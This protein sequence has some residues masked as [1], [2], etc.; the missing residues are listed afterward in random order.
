MFD[1]LGIVTNCLA[2][3][4]AH[5]DSFEKLIGEFVR[6]GFMHI[7]IR[8]GDYLRESAFGELLGEM[9]TAMSYYNDTDWQRLCVGLH[10]NQVHEIQGLR[11]RDRGLINRLGRF[12]Q[13]SPGMV[14]SY[15]LAHPWTS[16]PENASNDDRGIIRA[17]RLAY[18]FSPTHARLRLVDLNVKE[19]FQ[20]K[21]AIANLRRYQSLMTACPVTLAVEN[22]SL[23][24][25]IIL[26]L[27]V[28][29]NVRLAYDEANN[30]YQ[31]GTT[32]GDTEVFWERLKAHQLISIH[33]KQ[34]NQNGVC[35]SLGDG[36]VDL[37]VLF[38]RLLDRSY[39]GD[40]LLEYRATH[41]PLKDAIRSREFLSTCQNRKEST[42]DRNKK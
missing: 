21:D 37:P 8:D 42:R 18:L 22:S 12:L 7:E 3:C 15:A 36:F 34:K 41:Q 23:P 14:L 31:N 25:H 40:W 35:A 17:K 24:P 26:D 6:N 4:L 30:Y 27:A 10:K 5:N 19:A 9:E 38:K 33:L 28:Q 1:K 16:R 11:S 32:L 39:D 2:K 29:S 20:K 13:T